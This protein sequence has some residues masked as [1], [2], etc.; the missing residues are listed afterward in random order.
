MERMTWSEWEAFREKYPALAARFAKHHPRQVPKPPNPPVPPKYPRNGEKWTRAEDK[1]LQLYWGSYTIIKIT[2]ELGR[3]PRGIQERVSKLGLGPA[4]SPD[5]GASLTQFARRSGFSKRTILNAA[6]SLGI[7]LRRRKR[8][9]A[10]S[11]TAHIRTYCITPEQQDL[12]LGLLLLQDGRL[13]VTKGWNHPDHADRCL[14]C[15]RNDVPY[16]GRDR[17]RRCYARWNRKR[18]HADD[19]RGSGEDDT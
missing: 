6:R 8:T 12:I 7:R 10:T 18:K 19:V 14:G 16:F 13:V 3:P 17:C 5:A 2:K 15:K 4:T 1:Y 9:Y 11:A